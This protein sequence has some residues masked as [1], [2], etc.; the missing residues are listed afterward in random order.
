LSKHV[1]RKQHRLTIL[2]LR[3]FADGL[4]RR[5]DR[6]T[7]GRKQDSMNRGWLAVEQ[8][9]AAARATLPNTASLSLD[10]EQETW[11]NINRLANAIVIACDRLD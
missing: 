3:A 9:Y 5:A 7:T 8:L 4:A 11:T 6:V 10:G 2:E 1:D